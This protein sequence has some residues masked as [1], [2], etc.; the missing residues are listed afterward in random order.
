VLC[1]TYFHIWLFACIHIED[2]LVDLDLGKRVEIMYYI[3]QLILF[4]P[5]I[6]CFHQYFILQNTVFIFNYI[7]LCFIFKYLTFIMRCDAWTNEGSVGTEGWEGPRRQL[8]KVWERN[9]VIMRGSR[10]VFTQKG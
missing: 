9:N 7:Y 6:A 2:M 1:K 5:V 10:Y 8:W 3:A 4:S